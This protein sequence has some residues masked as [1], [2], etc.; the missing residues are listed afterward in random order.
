MTFRTWT[1]PGPGPGT[2]APSKPG[3]A[4]PPAGIRDFRDHPG[5]DIL[6]PGGHIEWRIFYFFVAGSLLNRR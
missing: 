5:L 1:G 3:R 6:N 4:S 2:P